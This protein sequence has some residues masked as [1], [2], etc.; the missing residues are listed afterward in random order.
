MQRSRRRDPYPFTWEIPVAAIA[1]VVMLLILG[2]H[3]GRGIANL[4]AGTGWM[5]PTREGFFRSLPQVLAGHAGAGLPHASTLT[6]TVDMLAGARSVQI[7][8]TLTELVEI[9]LC[10]WAM[11]EGLRRWGPS[12][13]HGMATRAEAE[14]LLGVSRLR[15]VRA[16][17][18][19]DLHGT[20]THRP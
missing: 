14:Q 15:R 9:S 13:I 11:V 20:R 2:V 1:A 17:V 6:H 18:R 12:Q 16:V 19:P 5:W 8:I 10:G 7:A 3:V 4:I